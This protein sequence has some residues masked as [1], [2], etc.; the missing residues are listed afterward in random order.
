MI[1]PTI[2]KKGKVNTN[3]YINIGL[4]TSGSFSTYVEYTINDT[5]CQSKTS[6][7]NYKNSTKTD[8]HRE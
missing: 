4:G 3:T 5:E 6:I 7:Y 2:D 1:D 8:L